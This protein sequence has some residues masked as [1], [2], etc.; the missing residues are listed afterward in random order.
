MNI[1]LKACPFCG[2]K[3]LSSEQNYVFCTKCG[4]IGPDNYDDYGDD[5]GSPHF[6]GTPFENWNERF[7]EKI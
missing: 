7:N 3:D 4:A 1:E 5:S 2:S 6:T